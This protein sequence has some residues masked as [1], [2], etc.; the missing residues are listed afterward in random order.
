VYANVHVKLHNVQ[1]QAIRL[2][3]TT[4]THE[5]N[6]KQKQE[7]LIKRILYTENLS[8]RTCGSRLLYAL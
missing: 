2:T 5:H 3:P 4:K 6:T 7:Q 1:L 8:M